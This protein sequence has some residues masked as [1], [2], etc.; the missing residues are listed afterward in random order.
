MS[1]AHDLSKDHNRDIP[2][3]LLD[4][5]EQIETT[6]QTALQDGWTVDKNQRLVLLLHSL[7]RSGA[8]LDFTKINS[9]A[10]A[11]EDDVS[12]LGDNNPSPEQREKMLGYLDLLK[13]EF[14]ME[15]RSLSDRTPH[16]A[17]QPVEVSSLDL[18]YLTNS[19]ADSQK[20]FITLVEQFGYRVHICSD[21]DRCQAVSGEKDPAVILVDTNF[22]VSTEKGIDILEYLQNEQPFTKP[23]IFISQYDNLQNRLRAIMAGGEAYLTIPIDFDNLIEKLDTVSLKPERGEPYRVLVVEDSLTLARFIHLT[24]EEAGISSFTVTDPFNIMRYIVD[25]HPDLILMDVYMPGCSG[26]QLAKVIRQMDAFVSIPIVY[27]SAETDIE[28]QLEALHQGGDDFL[29]KPIRPDHLISA[30]TYR[31]HRYR[32]LRRF[33]DHDSLT[34]LLNHSK[35]EMRL[36]EEMARAKRYQT[37]LAYAMLDLDKF[38]AINDNQGHLIGDRV[39]KGIARYLVKNLRNSDIVGR[40]GGEEYAII[41]P[42]TTAETAFNIMEKIR[43]SFEKISFQSYSGDFTF[44][45]TFTCGVASLKHQ[46]TAENLRMS[47]DQAMYLGKKQGRNQVILATSPETS[48]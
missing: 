22:Q 46:Q 30:V 19:S 11:F 47:A 3:F 8:V 43:T 32:D 40:Y 20:D 41:F 1:H 9:L 2:N 4:D 13:R 39:L 23:L 38:K 26:P 25:I 33:M 36:I 21:L 6:F 17:A 45:V 34:G 44:Q 18:L 28:K 5:L 48:L 16:G 27:L 7:A 24:L 29:T 35:I 31:I 14:H 42:M 15:K 10:S 12:A 37:D